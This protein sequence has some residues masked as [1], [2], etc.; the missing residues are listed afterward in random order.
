MSVTWATD[1]AGSVPVVTPAKPRPALTDE[2]HDHAIALA[3]AI[4]AA[5]AAEQRAL[6][7]RNAW[8]VAMRRRYP[9]WRDLPSV[10]A[11]VLGMDR[12]SVHNIIR[13]EGRH[14]N[15]SGRKVDA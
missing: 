2:Q 7:A 10:L 5:Q 8:I 9:D 15:R 6:A 11:S 1:H 12:T 14:P 4:E 13:H 3:E